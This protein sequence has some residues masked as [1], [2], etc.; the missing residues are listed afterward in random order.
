MNPVQHV[1]AQMPTIA[2]IYKSID[3]FL[4]TS[5]DNLITT[6][7]KAAL[8]VLG[9]A[10]AGAAAGAVI[11]GAGAVIVGVV[12]LGY[13][14]VSKIYNMLF[15]P[16]LQPAFNHNHR[17][18]N[19]I[20]RR[21][22]MLLNERRTLLELRAELQRLDQHDPLWNETLRLNAEGLRLLDEEIRRSQGLE[23]RLLNAAPEEDPRQILMANLAPQ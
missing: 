9:G 22:R 14:A 17:L 1:T 3:K 5:T 18:G 10:L 6:I 2:S 8:A 19:M 21:N 16:H 7:A 13:T 15:P 4:D 20:G 12:W 23:R 11:V